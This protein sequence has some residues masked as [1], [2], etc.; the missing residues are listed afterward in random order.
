MCAAQA[1]D[2]AALLAARRMAHRQ[3]F[4]AELLCAPAVLKAA[5]LRLQP[6]VPWR[7]SHGTNRHYQSLSTA[8]ARPAGASLNETPA[9]QPNTD[10]LGV[11]G[12]LIAALPPWAARITTV[13]GLSG[14]PPGGRIL[15]R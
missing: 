12:L 9:K 5:D 15:P 8:A 3:A 13:R 1:R 10:H 14:L 2:T 4:T 6:H 7:C 11:T